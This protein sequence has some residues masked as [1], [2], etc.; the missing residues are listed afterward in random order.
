M[1]LATILGVTFVP[2]LYVQFQRLREAAKRN[3]AQPEMPPSA[4][5]QKT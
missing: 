3:R 4:K 1:L 2:F 5:T